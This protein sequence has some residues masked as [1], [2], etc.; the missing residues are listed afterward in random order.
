MNGMTEAAGQLG[1]TDYGSSSEDHTTL[2]SAVSEL[3]TVCLPGS[4]GQA[5]Y[6]WM[7][8]LA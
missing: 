7:A 1:S 3:G 2:D 4:A 8:E 6:C 5:I